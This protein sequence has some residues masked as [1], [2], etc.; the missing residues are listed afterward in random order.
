MKPLGIHSNLIRFLQNKQCQ[1]RLRRKGSLGDFYRA[2]GDHI[3]FD[4]P[5]E[6]GDLVMDV[7]GYSGDWTAAIIAR[8]GCHSEIFEPIPEFALKCQERFALN[9]RVNVHKEALGGTNRKTQFSIDQLASSEFDDRPENLVTA[10]VVDVHGVVETLR[11]QFKDIACIKLNV[12][13]GEYEILERLINSGT[14]AQIRSIIVQ[15]HPQPEGW[16]ERLASIEAQLCLTHER[17]WGFPMIWEK[18]IR[19]C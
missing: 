15:Y 1:A 3:L 4:I 10:N 18:W 17:A 11:A 12:E 9:A 5:A 8:Y 13:G 14:I 7:G 16:Q 6:C 2:G 19:K